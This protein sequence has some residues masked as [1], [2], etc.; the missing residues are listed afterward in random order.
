[1]IYTVQRIGSSFLGDGVAFCRKVFTN[2]DHR[3]LTYSCSRPIRNPKNA[4]DL[5]IGQWLKQIN[6]GSEEDMIRC[7]HLISRALYESNN[8]PKSKE[9][10]IVIYKLGKETYMAEVEGQLRI[11]DNCFDIEKCSINSVASVLGNTILFNS[12]S[13]WLYKAITNYRIL[14]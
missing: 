9:R 4:D 11:T 12:K 7:S 2:I 14:L 1:M 13:S 5:V 3:A 8:N 10:V 6:E